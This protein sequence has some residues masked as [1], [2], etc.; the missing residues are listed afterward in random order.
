[1]RGGN[2]SSTSDDLGVLHDELDPED[3]DPVGE[4][5]GDVGDC[6]LGDEVGGEEGGD[7]G[8]EGDGEGD[9]EED[10]EGDGD[11]DG[12]GDGEEGGEESGEEGGEGDL[13][14]LPAPSADGRSPAS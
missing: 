7:R 4:S 2:G 10:G 12:V 1:M 6:G 5:G 14:L 8:G 9:S 3:E 13:G 11:G